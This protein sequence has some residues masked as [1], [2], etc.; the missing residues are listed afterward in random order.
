MRHTACTP[1]PVRPTSLLATAAMTLTLT[2]AACQTDRADVGQAGGPGVT[3]AQRQMPPANLALN[4]T[5]TNPAN[6]SIAVGTASAPVRPTKDQTANGVVRFVPARDGTVAVRVELR[7]MAPG[8]VHGLHIHEKGDCSAPDAA[9]AGAHFNPAGKSH[10]GP[11]AAE[12]HA[13]DLG[14][15]T[16][17]DTG[18]VNTAIS[19]SDLSLAQGD[20][21]A[22]GRSVVLHAK[23]DD[24]KSQPAGDSGGRIACG[25]IGRDV[26]GGTVG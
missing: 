4:D 14:N 7:G 18:A 8:S 15:V 3:P 22:M 2:L 10:G 6:R 5:V 26:A 21:S 13:G 12:R 1:A 17:D 20:D 23:A 16:A 25:V 9:S 11:T 24:L 19:V